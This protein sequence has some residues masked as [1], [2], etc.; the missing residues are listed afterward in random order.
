MV[1]Y[2]RAITNPPSFN[3]IR[4]C[5]DTCFLSSCER[6]YMLNWNN[7]LSNEVLCIKFGG[8]VWSSIGRFVI[9]IFSNRF[10]SEI[11][12]NRYYYIIRWNSNIFY[13]QK[14]FGNDETSYTC[15]IGIKWN[16]SW[17]YAVTFLPTSCSREL[18]K[19]TD[20]CQ[21][22]C[23]KQYVTYKARVLLSFLWKDLWTVPHRVYWYNTS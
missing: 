18:E 13:P 14:F 12:D 3:A 15:W 20:R 21:N 8:I 7:K 19:K 22:T 11:S 4:I 17:I 16:R 9:R 5:N 1:V 10:M 23:S 2:T 6:L